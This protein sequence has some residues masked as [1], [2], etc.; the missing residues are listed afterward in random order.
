MLINI[1]FP[2]FRL[3]FGERNVEGMLRILEPLHN[4]M[5]R[6][7]ETIK[8]TSFT[9]AY[10]RDLSEAHDWCQKYKVF[11]YFIILLLF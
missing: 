11:S 6:G 1:E 9:Q 5:Q 7:P 3:Y 8:E 2:F 4:M 10:G